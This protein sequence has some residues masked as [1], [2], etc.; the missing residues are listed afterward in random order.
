MTGAVIAKAIELA[1]T[2]NPRDNDSRSPAQRR[3]EALAD[4]CNF[5]VDYQHRVAT[6][7]DAD[8]PVVP[9]KRNW[10]QLIGVTDTTDDIANHAGAQLL[11]GPRIDHQAFEAL[12]GTAQLLRLVLDETVRS[13]ATK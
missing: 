12:S 5:Y 13:A 10:P 2:D 11:N 3:G 1:E 4:V 7:P 9:K 6:D 8:A